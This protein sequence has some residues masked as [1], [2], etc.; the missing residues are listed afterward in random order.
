MNACLELSLVTWHSEY[1]RPWGLG[2]LVTGFWHQAMD[3]R[4]KSERA[5]PRPLYGF[6]K[7]YGSRRRTHRHPFPE[8]RGQFPDCLAAMTGDTSETCWANH[9][10]GHVSGQPPMWGVLFLDL[11]AHKQAA[12][13][14]LSGASSATS[15]GYVFHFRAQGG[16][17][18]IKQDSPW[19]QTEERLL[20]VCAP[21]TPK[22][23]APE[24]FRTEA[25]FYLA[26]LVSCAPACNW[27]LEPPS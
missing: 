6:R 23:W 12:K 17:W 3:D 11:D 8:H 24:L 2:I 14:H 1:R 16:W 19:A 4:V 15:S 20:Q 18:T 25:S 5:S 26:A 7:L 9:Q 27:N 13:L 22:M 10:E 21:A